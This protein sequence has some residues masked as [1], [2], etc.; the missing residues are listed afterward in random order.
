MQDQLVAVNVW[1]HAPP[2]SEYGD[3]HDCTGVAVVLCTHVIPDR[4]EGAVHEYTVV[5]M[6]ASEASHAPSPTAES[7]SG[8][9]GTT[10]GDGLAVAVR[11]GDRDLVEL[12]VTVGVGDAV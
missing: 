6:G 4:A 2:T 3:A 1:E 11:F 12:M 5:A 8:Q 10:Q 9:I 7:P